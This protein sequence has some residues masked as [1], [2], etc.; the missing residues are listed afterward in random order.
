MASGLE[1]FLTQFTDEELK[2]L[3][4]TKKSTR[5]RYP[6]I[7]KNFNER[8]PY[9]QSHG[10]RSANITELELEEAFKASKYQP[11]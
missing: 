1:R 7:V 11:R 5:K 6:W 8:F 10:L 3:I 4:N 2:W 9:I